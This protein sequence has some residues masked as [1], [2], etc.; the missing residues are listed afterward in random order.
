MQDTL[1]TQEKAAQYLDCSA[2]ALEKWRVWGTGPAYIKVSRKMV[3]YKR[4]DL[5]R[6]LAERRVHS[7]SD[8]G[9][10]GAR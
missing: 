8:P 1:L 2:R 6:F 3:R 4:E 5:D 10:G 9:P 7:T